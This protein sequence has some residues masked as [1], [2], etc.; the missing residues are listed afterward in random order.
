MTGG[1]TRCEPG[2][3][4]SRS[5]SVFFQ[6]EMQKDRPTPPHGRRE[7]ATEMEYEDFEIRLE[8]ADGETCCARVVSSP[9]GTGRREFPRPGLKGELVGLRT[10][11]ERG[12]D[13]AGARE[14][15]REL[16]TDGTVESLATRSHEV[17]RGLFDA[18]FADEILELYLQSL[19][20]VSE[21]QE[22]GLRIKLSFDPSSPTGLSLCGLPWELLYRSAT[23]ESPALSRRTP[24]VRHLILRTG[25]RRPPFQPPLRIL[26]V[27][28]NP[29]GTRRLGL[30]E[31]LAAI[32][33]AAAGRP[34]VEVVAVQSP[35]PQG[36]REALG[37]APC[38]YLHF[39][40]HGSFERSVGRG[41]LL[42]ETDEGGLERLGSEDFVTLLRD[43]TSLRLVVLN[44]CLT[45]AVDS[46]LAP[47]PFAGVATA[48]MMA[49]IPTVVG[50][51]LPIPD[52]TAITFSKALYEHLLAG[53][54]VDAAVVEARHAV[55]NETL[56]SPLF[57][58]AIPVVY[59]QL[60]GF[61]EEPPWPVERLRVRR[62]LEALSPARFEQ[63]RRRIDAGEERSSGNGVEGDG[64]A[65]G[66][67]AGKVSSARSRESAERLVD[68]AIERGDSCWLDLQESALAM[69]SPLAIF[70]G[71]FRGWRRQPVNGWDLARD[72]LVGSGRG[73]ATFPGA[74]PDLRE[75]ASLVWEGPRFRD[76]E[77]RARLGMP[78][79]GLG[80]TAGLLLGDPE[81]GGLVLGLLRSTAS[82]ACA[83]IHQQ[84]SLGWRTLIS[85]EL[86]DLAGDDGW[87]RVAL[88]RS[89]RHVELR[90]DDEEPVAARL[91]A[92]V[93]AGHPGLVRFGGTTVE[94]RD[95][96]LTV[97]GRV[98]EG[99]R[100]QGEWT[101]PGA[102]P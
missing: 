54:S 101:D 75:A 100:G 28:S 24:V 82:G 98:D 66:P 12:R 71:S 69:R 42:L 51:L 5:H 35:T 32:E 56:S 60:P 91:G 79:L 3:Y 84:E 21:E 18:V 67:G 23:R 94:A 13:R 38:H 61:P 16:D 47:D 81:W 58:W 2:T 31:E 44:A 40:G 43:H 63:V 89:R 22:R 76:G 83:E 29:S 87:H 6:S 70:E 33:A 53:C 55:R 17:G 41:Q 19:K 48:L 26:V 10:V 27:G 93:P 68:L 72:L 50:M 46:Q 95:L 7:R 78:T 86:T 4:T 34:G 77:L 59:T 96:L 39:M 73:V 14:Q 52:S 30:R 97:V 36:L 99:G 102:W 11:L 62:A 15:P 25:T 85:R 90:I 88:N 37:K 64:I 9:A 20:V 49:E 92:E 74:P 45:A 65:M 1:R 57:E 80:G 8:S